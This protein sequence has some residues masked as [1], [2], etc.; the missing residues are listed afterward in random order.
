MTSFISTALAWDALDEDLKAL[1]AER[2]VLHEFLDESSVA[3]TFAHLRSWHPARM[4]H[5]RT[6]RPLLFVSE[7]NVREIEG[8]DREGSAPL[9]ARVFA[10]L[11]APEW[12][13]DHVWQPGDFLVWD[14]RSLQHAR[15]EVA[16]PADGPRVMQRVALGT[17]SFGE[18]FEALKAA[19]A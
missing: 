18:Q 14:N 2:R 19:A 15:P 17:A 9:L 4:A 13:Y 11:Y 8:L 12:R 10:A 7:N 6:G 5:P 16:D 1:L 3:E